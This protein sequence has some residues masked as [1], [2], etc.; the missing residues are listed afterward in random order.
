ML[1][2]SDFDKADQ[3][4]LFLGS[5]VSMLCGSEDN[6]RVAAAFTFYVELVGFIFRRRVLFIQSKETLLEIEEKIKEF[7]VKSMRMFEN[8][9]ASKMGTQKWHT[10]DHISVSIR[11]VASVEFLHARII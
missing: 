6:A 4:S 1:E 10:L 7:K 2:V 9:Q 11:E 3:N 5:L 8:Y